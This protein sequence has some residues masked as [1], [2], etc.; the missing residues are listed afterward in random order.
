M[1][2]IGSAYINLLILQLVFFTI[3]FFYEKITKYLKNKFRLQKRSYLLF[4]PRDNKKYKFKRKNQ[5]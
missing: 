5:I 2:K 1:S 3:Y 4:F